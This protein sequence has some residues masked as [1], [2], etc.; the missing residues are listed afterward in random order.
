MLT[1]R[2]DDGG[3]NLLGQWLLPPSNTGGGCP[4]NAVTLVYLLLCILW[5][6]QP[7]DLFMFNDQLT[8]LVTS[9]SQTTGLSSIEIVSL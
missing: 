8:F 2:D 1:A 5:E 4:F 3:H 9:Q 6:E 7:L